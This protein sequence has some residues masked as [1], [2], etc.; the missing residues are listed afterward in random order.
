MIIKK[1]VE[2]VSKNGNLL[3][4]IGPDSK[5]N[6]PE[7]SVE[8]LEQIG[9]WMD[10]NRDSIYNCGG[11]ELEKPEYGRITQNGKKNIITLWKI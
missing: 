2:C 4:N 7:E 1:L 8:I 5:G 6:V 10:K 9:K 11:S 3:L